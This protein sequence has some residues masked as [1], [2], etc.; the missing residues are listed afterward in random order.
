[1]IQKNIAITQRLDEV[2]DYGETRESL[3]INWGRFINNLSYI[4]C[5]LSSAINI[6]DFFEQNPF[7]GVLF[8]GG[9]NLSS[10]KPSKLS[11]SRDH[12]ETKLISFCLSKKIPIL[13][14]CRGMQI[15][16]Q[17]FNGK[18]EP[19]D[20]HV[21]THHNLVNNKASKWIKELNAIKTVN[22]FH[23]YSVSSVPQE[24]IVSSVDETTNGIEAIEHKKLPVFC[25][26]W[27]PERTV[28]FS[29][30]ESQLIK[31]FFNSH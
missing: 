3:D 9:N 16:A 21:K 7:H 31:K 30:E 11:T 18:I 25:Q 15:I 14:V 2:S 26:M 29:I 10:L 13:G 17:Y 27:H 6:H 22:S 4:P 12:F 20:G 8:S 1:M 28:P 23:D 5:P 24:F 19:I